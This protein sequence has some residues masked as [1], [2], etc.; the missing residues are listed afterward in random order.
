MVNSAREKEREREKEKEREREREVELEAAL[1]TNCLLLGL[2]AALLVPNS[3]GAPRTGLFRH[4]N[5]RLG[6]TLLHF[7]LCALRGPSQSAKDFAGVWPI[8][9]SAQ[10]RDFRKIVQG[11]INELESQ[12]ALP[13]SNSRVSLLATCC[14]HRFVELL[15]QLSAHALREVHKRT[16][17]ADVAS[18]PLP[19]SLADVVNQSSHASALLTVTKARIALERKRFLE[20]TGAAVQRQALW[21]SLA[22]DMTAE[23]R[24]LSAEEAYLHQEL[25]KLQESNNRKVDLDDDA[26]DCDEHLSSDQKTLSVSRASH[27]WECLLTHTDQHEELASGPIEDLIAHREHRYRISGSALR[28]A[29][30]NGSNALPADSA[31]SLTEDINY[32]HKN[33]E[34]ILQHAGPMQDGFRDKQDRSLRHMEAQGGEENSTRVDERTGKYLSVDV[35]EILRRWTHALQRI[36]K[37]SVRLARASDGAGPQLLKSTTDFVGNGHVEALQATLAEH[38]NHLTNIQVLVGQLKDAMPGMESAISMLR[39]EV[40]RVSTASDVRI[41]QKTVAESPLRCRDNDK[42]G[43]ANQDVEGGSKIVSAALEL[44]PPTPA[45]KL[46]QLFSVSPFPSEKDGFLQKHRSSVI[47]AHNLETLQEFDKPNRLSPPKSLRNEDIEDN[48]N[49]DLSSLR[50]AVRNAAL[51]RPDIQVDPSR[52]SFDN[53]NDHYF[54]PLSSTSSFPKRGGSNN[55]TRQQ[56]NLRVLTSIGENYDLMQDSTFEKMKV[57]NEKQ[58]ERSSDVHASNRNQHSDS[59]ELGNSI[60]QDSNFVEINSQS[61]GRESMQQFSPPLLSELSSFSES[62]DDLLAPLSEV[63]AAVMDSSTQG[64]RA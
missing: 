55:S 64:L 63:E 42:E 28:A 36:H 17:T 38:Q 32:R 40:S 37:Q 11:I 9:D 24:A 47:Q 5:P 61:T 49:S 20:S 53:D 46:P 39:E 58:F 60:V 35:A 18:N 34:E 14:G 23:F 33:V 16:F 62:Y 54:L 12:G 50:R 21:S 52:E 27:L 10:S 44:I 13:R 8:F 3:N 22:H 29:I 45:L 56:T 48:G 25:E 51:S 57:Y 31:S 59:S 26:E 6:E 30:D 15:W 4:S 1:Y 43:I 19:A 2:D 7:L 41:E